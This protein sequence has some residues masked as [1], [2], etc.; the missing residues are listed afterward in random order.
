MMNPTDIENLQGLDKYKYDIYEP[1]YSCPVKK[2]RWG[3][4]SQNLISTLQE[5]FTKLE[6]IHPVVEIEESN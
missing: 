6:N 3:V 1:N 4:M 5:S 2:S